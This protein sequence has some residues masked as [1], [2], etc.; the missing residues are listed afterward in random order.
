M[1]TLANRVKVA[2]ASTGT[3]SPITLGAAKDGFQTFDSA[4]ITNGQTVRY[5]IEDGT[6]FE[7]GTGVYTAS[8][9]TLTRVLTESTT[10]SLLNLSGDSTVFVTAA[11]ED[12][13]PES[14]GT[15]S[16]NVSF[17][18]Y[19]DHTPISP[20]SESEGRLFYDSTTKTFAYNSDVS[21]VTHELGI[22]E[23]QRVYNNTGST[24]GKGKPLYFAGNY[25]SGS[26]DVPT[27]GL[28]D[29]TDINAY[30]AQ[31]LAAHDIANN[32]YGYCI[33]AGQLH[34]VD[35]SGLS[36]GTNFFVGLTPGAVQNASPVYPNFPMCLG[37]VVN[38]D[39]TNGVLLVNQQNH[40][41]RS[42]RVQTSAHIGADLQVDGD[43]TVIGT[44]TSVSTADVTAG[45]PFYR[46]NEGDSIGE[47]G[48]TFVGTGLDDAFFAGHFTG[49][50]NTTYYVKIDSVGTPDT[51]AVSLDDFT[52]TISTGNAITGNPQLIHSADNIS[53]EFGATTGHTLNDKW[54]GT[55]GPTNVD[56]GFF[57]NRNTGT[58]GVGYTHIG[59]YFDVTDAKWKFLDEYD[60]VPQGSIDPT[61]PSYSLGTVAASTFEGALVGNVTGNVTGDVTGIVTGSLN[62]GTADNIVFEGAT[63]DDF[64][65]TV[66]VVDPTA[67]RT[68]TFADSSGTV[69][70]T[71]NL[72]DITNLGVLT[73]DIV[74]EG[75][76]ADTFETT[77]TVVD[78]TAD[79]SISLPNK[80]G[81]IVVADTTTN[82]ITLTSTD[83]TSGPFI[84]IVHDKAS[85]V[86]LEDVGAIRVFANEAQGGTQQDSSKIT[87][88]TTNSLVGQHAG[89]I[90]FSAGKFDASGLTELMTISDLQ[91]VT[92]KNRPLALDE[93]IN[94]KFEGATSN[95]NETTL[96]VVD[97]TQ[98]NTV[99][100]PDESGTL[101][102]KRRA[103][104]YSIIFG[105]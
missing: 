100:L 55:A 82:N 93:G 37:W 3:S 54:E 42:F 44:T 49:T 2:C 66:T 80:S 52:T 34:G 63:T 105:G 56:T 26:I 68:I 64:E 20:P 24:I 67:D 77:L 18:N 13:V 10:G 86:G 72:T 83:N 1:V 32:S 94:I 78:P 5:T 87:F 11:S 22:E 61:D 9:T 69:I 97:P 70:T 23:H 99:S 104:A 39:A 62:L 41:V 40:S 59:M 21:G 53:V 8:G 15:F 92:I 60:P 57:S 51:F 4:G 19:N 6:S 7:I 90:K 79:R 71:G 91:G 14:G 30:N 102:T 73:G 47:A 45:A 12:L 101:V 103:L 65:T 25:V 75:S 84:N 38:S 48:T 76:T 29:A 16:G 43:L 31:G 36:A 81:D 95:N 33:I 98:D 17:Q 50:T 46:A 85:P 96:T 88:G 89:V 58:T 74:F 28:A 27:V 35:T